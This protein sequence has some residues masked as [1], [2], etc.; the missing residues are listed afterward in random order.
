MNPE[1]EVRKIFRSDMK[2][3]S[4]V[5][6]LSSEI[7]RHLKLPE[8]MRD[9]LSIAVTEAVGNAIVHGNKCDPA[10]KVEVT[11]TIEPSRI[12]VAVR[13]EGGG[14]NPKT[15]SN[16]LDPENL[17]KESGRGIFILKTLMDEVHF[18]FSNSGTTVH[19]TMLTTV[20]TS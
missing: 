18:S 2:V 6:R 14:F 10:K 5:E 7:A 1:K 13:D 9:N 17:M 19:F 16:P 20:K 15:L 12:R 4:K 8:D 11:F 3:L